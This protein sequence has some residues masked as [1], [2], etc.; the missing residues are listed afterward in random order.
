MFREKVSIASQSKDTTKT[1]GLSQCL[2]GLR[3]GKNNK[4]EKIITY[5]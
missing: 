1:F 4:E 5:I 2:C 3:P